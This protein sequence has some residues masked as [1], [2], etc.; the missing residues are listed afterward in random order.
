MLI[1]ERERVRI[2][3]ER[4]EFH[5]ADV[6]ATLRVVAPTVRA[7]VRACALGIAREPLEARRRGVIAHAVEDAL[8]DD[9][10]AGRDAEAV[11]IAVL[12]HF[13][14]RAITR[15]DSGTMRPVSMFI[16]RIVELSRRTVVKKRRR[17]TEQIRVHCERIAIVQSTVSHR[18]RHAAAVVAERLH[19]QQIRPAIARDDL[20]SDLVVQLHLRRGLDPQHGVR[21]CE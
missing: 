7:D 4:V 3:H 19:R 16:R 11:K 9:A 6:V 12:V 15:D 17:A 14:T 21:R 18:H 8:R 13:T 20:G 10:R 5:R 1:A 2:A